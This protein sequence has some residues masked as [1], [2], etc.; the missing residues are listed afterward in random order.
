MRLIAPDVRRF[1]RVSAHRGDTVLPEDQVAATPLEVP[2]AR[3]AQHFCLGGAG[4]GE[5]LL[6]AFFHPGLEIHPRL[7]G[8]GAAQLEPAIGQL[9][10]GGAINQLL[11]FAHVPDHGFTATFRRLDTHESDDFGRMLYIGHFLMKDH[12]PVGRGARRFHDLA[13]DRR[14]WRAAAEVIARVKTQR[15]D[16]PFK[17]LGIPA[18]RGTANEHRAFTQQLCPNV[19]RRRRKIARRIGLGA[20]HKIECP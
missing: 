1:A 13:L 18:R 4:S 12:R 10:Q 3:P 2:T 11:Q 9:L 16:G 17:H 7:A 8:Q 20:D 19:L 14:A 6:P 15:T 5:R